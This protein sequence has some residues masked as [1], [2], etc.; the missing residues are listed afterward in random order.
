MTILALNK[1]NTSNFVLS[2]KKGGGGHDLVDKLPHRCR[3]LPVE[4]QLVANRCIKITVVTRAIAFRSN[5]DDDA[6]D[7][8]DAGFDLL[9]L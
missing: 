1:I 8:D 5:V 6:D 4:Q 9:M 2:L 7:D 3:S